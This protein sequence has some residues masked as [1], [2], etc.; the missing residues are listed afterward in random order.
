MNDFPDAQ[1]PEILHQVKKDNEVLQ[2]FEKNIAEGLELFIPAKHLYSNRALITS[3]TSLFYYLSN[4]YHL[5]QTLGEEYAYI[6]QYHK[7]ES[8]Y[9]SKRRML[10][11]AF[12]S[13]FGVI[14]IKKLAEKL[15]TLKSKSILR[16]QKELQKGYDLKGEDD[17]KA[18]KKFRRRYRGVT[19]FLRFAFFYFQKH[20][21]DVSVFFD[22]VVGLNLAI[23]YLNG[24]FPTIIKRLLGIE[25]KSDV[26]IEPHAFSYEK[27][28]W[29]ILTKYCL[30]IASYS[31]SSFKNAYYHQKDILKK[32]KKSESSQALDK[33][34][35]EEGKGKKGKVLQKRG[36]C[37]ICFDK[38]VRTA[39]TPCGHLFCYECILKSLSYKLECPICRHKVQVKEVIVLANYS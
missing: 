10:L 8:V 22:G 19:G 30:T 14:G 23:F 1:Q 16:F 34:S 38:R 2:K 29:L 18:L 31:F 3:L 11:F 39:V 6:R 20:F 33:A 15:N 27:I 12:I 35:T 36:I 37:G 7:N 17:K 28:G 32:L 25:Y 13:S 9:L 5:K 4:S 24:R 26:K 21:G